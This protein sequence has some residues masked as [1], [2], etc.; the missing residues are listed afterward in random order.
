MP[1]PAN[2]RP[3]GN[4]LPRNG[5][6]RPRRLPIAERLPRARQEL[7]IER[8]CQWRRLPRPERREIVHFGD[9]APEGVAALASLVGS[10]RAVLKGG[11]SP[12]R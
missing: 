1:L 2:R 6:S 8:P 3:N 4:P 12:G 5:N 11:E 9:A 10:L 7:P